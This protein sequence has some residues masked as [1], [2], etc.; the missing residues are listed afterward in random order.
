MKYTSFVFAIFFSVCG[1]SSVS[2]YGSYEK[3]QSAKGGQNIVY[4]S[5]NG[6]YSQGGGTPP[7]PFYSLNQPLGGKLSFYWSGGTLFLR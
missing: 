4:I 2:A 6:Y 5:R 1:L 7:S 3:T